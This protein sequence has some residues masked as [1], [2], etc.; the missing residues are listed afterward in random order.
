MWNSTTPRIFAHQLKEKMHNSH[1][2]WL[3]QCSRV[4]ILKPGWWA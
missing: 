4:L 1:R 3:L 2:G